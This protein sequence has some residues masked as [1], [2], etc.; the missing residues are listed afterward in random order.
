VSNGQVVGPLIAAGVTDDNVLIIG[1]R[2]DVE[3]LVE[4][5]GIGGSALV[6]RLE[7]G[8]RPG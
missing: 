5:S 7:E 1:K 2:P 3:L 4:C 6:N 8:V